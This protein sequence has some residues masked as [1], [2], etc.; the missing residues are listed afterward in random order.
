MDIGQ[1]WNLAVSTASE[2]IRRLGWELVMAESNSIQI[3]LMRHGYVGVG[4]L[5]LRRCRLVRVPR[6]QRQRSSKTHR[7]SSSTTSAHHSTYDLFSESGGRPVD[8]L[9]SQ[10]RKRGKMEVA[11]NTQRRLLLRV[12]DKNG[13]LCGNSIYNPVRQGKGRS[14]PWGIYSNLGVP[15]QR[16]RPSEVG[17]RGCC[18]WWRVHRVGEWE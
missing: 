6:G 15:W 13:V 10:I 3:L 17:L 16:C 12:V 9:P 7:T 5:A 4:L 2:S 8:N 11:H 14:W 18:R 1:T